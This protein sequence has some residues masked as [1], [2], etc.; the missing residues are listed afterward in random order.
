MEAKIENRELDPQQSLKLITSI[1]NES[2]K[3]LEKNAGTPMILWGT[4][5]LITSLVIWWLWSGTGNPQ[6]NL[7]WLA[8]GVV[9]YPMNYLW[10]RKH[11]VGARTWLDSVLGYVWTLFGV[12]SIVLAVLCF[13]WVLMPM[14]ALVMLLLGFATALTGVLTKSWLII[15]AGTVTALVGVS[16][17]FTLAPYDMIP[18]FAGAALITLI[19]PGVVMNVNSKRR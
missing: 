3:T 6:W 15:C 4:L 17:S 9:G 2:R 18:L 16:L 14:V 1:I 5:T 7:L 12:F 13:L 11:S 19:L 10:M 8:M